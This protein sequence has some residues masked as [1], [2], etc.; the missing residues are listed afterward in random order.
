M[1]GSN[2]MKTTLHELLIG[3]LRNQSGKQEKPEGKWFM[4]VNNRWLERGKRLAGMGWEELRVRSCQELAKRYALVLSPIGA[5]FL[6][7][8]FKSSPETSG[9]LFFHRETGSVNSSLFPQ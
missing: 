7:G 1:H 4:P 3:Y 5:Y 6:G 9:W 2:T 8:D